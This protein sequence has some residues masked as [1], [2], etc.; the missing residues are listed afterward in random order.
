MWC[1]YLLHN[2]NE[3]YREVLKWGCML[4]YQLF[5]ITAQLQCCHEINSNFAAVL[6][7][8]GSFLTLI[9]EDINRELWAALMGSFQRKS[10]LFKQNYS[11]ISTLVYFLQV[12]CVSSSLYLHEGQTNHHT[13]LEMYLGSA[14][15]CYWMLSIAH[16]WLWNATNTF[17]L[18][19]ALYICLKVYLVH[20]KCRQRSFCL[21]K[22]WKNRGLAYTWLTICFRYHNL[23]IWCKICVENKVEY[24]QSLVIQIMFQGQEFI[25]FTSNKW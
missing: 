1:C 12:H 14:P 6:L 17:G 13:D 25:F 19:C 2:G 7:R 20:H 15:Q 5:I 21:M 22:C 11:L 8:R 16:L 18:E 10:N 4:H 23:D 3:C 24:L 9:R